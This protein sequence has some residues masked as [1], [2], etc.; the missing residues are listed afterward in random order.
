MINNIH[1]AKVRQMADLPGES[2]NNN[3]NNINKENDNNN[4]NKKH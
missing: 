2:N 3:N 4:N 1:E